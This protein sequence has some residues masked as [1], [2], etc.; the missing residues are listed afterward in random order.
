MEFLSITIFR[1]FLNKGHCNSSM[2]FRSRWHLFNS[3]T[4]QRAH[5]HTTNFSIVFKANRFLQLVESVKLGRT[6]YL[7]INWLEKWDILGYIFPTNVP[8]VT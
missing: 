7:P 4:V 2:K 3:L 8:M 6:E 5:C 1:R